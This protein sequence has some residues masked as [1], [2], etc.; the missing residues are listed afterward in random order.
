MKRLMG[1]LMLTMI[2]ISVLVGCG[3]GDGGDGVTGVQMGGSIQGIPLSL[4]GAV[5]TL[6]GMAGADGS[7]D[8]TGTAARFAL[9]C[10]ITTDGTNLYVADAYNF[11]I[12]KVVIATGEVTTMAGT[13]D[14]FGS[15]DGTGAAAR[16]FYPS[17]ITTDGTNLYVADTGNNTIRKVVIATGVVTTL[18]GTAG[19]YG[20]TD[21]AGEA[22]SFS[23]PHGITT[24]GT[25][26]YVADTL[27]CTIRKVVIATSVVT[28]VAGNAGFFG[29]TDGT[30]AEARFS[31]PYGITTDG[32]NLFVADTSNHTIRQVVIAT[33]VVT[34]LAGTAGSSD[35]TDG[36][37][38]AARFIYPSDITTDGT[39]LYVADTFNCTIRKVVIT[40]GVVT[41]VAGTAGSEGSTDGTGA[42]AR[43]DLPYGITTDGTG[44]FVADTS[45]YTIRGV[46]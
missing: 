2:T 39:N 16:F 30:G 21:G 22:A 19:S 37:G 7:T 26:L 20:S 6:V 35:S 24:D 45:N 43:F 5:T 4:K 17:G 41:T 40:T 8:D 25:N 27:N 32:T 3:G 11:S 1:L 28:T 42:E 18:A 29:S 36:T 44:L 12:R 33:G 23:G 34:T 13:A 31:Y 38:T 14:T 10:G 46:D 9:P 15:T